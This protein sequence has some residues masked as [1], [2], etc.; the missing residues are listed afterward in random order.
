L[1]EK[2]S[3]GDVRIKET[4]GCDLDSMWKIANEFMIR[5]TEVGKIPITDNDFRDY[6]FYAYYNCI[7]L[8]LIKYKYVKAASEEEDDVPF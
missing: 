4:L 1:L 2:T 5:H 6:L 8:I 7:R 3:G